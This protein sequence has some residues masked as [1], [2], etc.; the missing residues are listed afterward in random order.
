M[1][2]KQKLEFKR[3]PGKAW[4]RITSPLFTTLLLALITAFSGTYLYCGSGLACPTGNSKVELKKT[5]Q[6]QA[7]L[8]GV[9]CKPCLKALVDEIKSNEA[10]RRVK[11]KTKKQKFNGKK[12]GILKVE[13]KSP[14]FSKEDLIEI[15]KFRDFLALEVTD[16]PK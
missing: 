8:H 14:G 4:S 11:L 16:L 6:F 1:S 15:I 3:M 7:E 5:R 10:V 12:Y 13:Y 9:F 2:V